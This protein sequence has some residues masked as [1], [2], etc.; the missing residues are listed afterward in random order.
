MRWFKND[1]MYVVPEIVLKRTVR[2]LEPA[3]P[4]RVFS[5][6]FVHPGLKSN[7]ILVQLVTIYCI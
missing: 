2:F 1:W 3:A 7:K 4:N 5:V 6:F